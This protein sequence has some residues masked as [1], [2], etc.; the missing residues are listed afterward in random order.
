MA[1]APGLD[2]TAQ[3]YNLHAA[4]LRRFATARLRSDVAAEDTVQEAFLRLAI[5]DRAGRY[6][7]QPRA[8]LYR[9][10]LNVIISGARRSR[11]VSS[12][13]LDEQ[14]E[15]ADHETPETRFLELERQRGLN[16]IMAAVGS[17]GRTGLVLAAHG[18][19]GLEIAGIVGRSEGAT[20]ALLCRTRAS[21]R[22][23]LSLAEAI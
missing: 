12:E 21:L 4:E 8:W 11:R 6:P 23:T 15:P 5:E 3:A 20:R 22:Q 10:A 17:S 16:V 2:R 1:E 9:V 7:S 14:P 19:S 13:S 18:Y